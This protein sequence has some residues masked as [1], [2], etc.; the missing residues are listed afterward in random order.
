M[1]ERTEETKIIKYTLAKAG[2]QDIRVSHGTGTSWSWVTVGVSLLRPENCTCDL[3]DDNRYPYYCNAC[4]SAMTGERAKVTT[5]VVD[6]TGRRWGD[7][8]GNTIV[9]IN[10]KEVE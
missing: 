1:Y 8:D 4:R 3:T 9:V 2:Y 7:Y 5:L 10:I 6:A